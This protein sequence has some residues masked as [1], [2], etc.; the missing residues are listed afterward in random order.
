MQDYLVEK[1][2]W[3]I[4]SEN[5][6]PSETEAL[7]KFQLKL[8]MAQSILRRH[9]NQEFRHMVCTTDNTQAVSDI[10]AAMKTKH[11]PTDYLAIHVA[12][13]KMMN[14]KFKRADV[15]QHIN[16]FELIA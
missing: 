10:C 13:S 12:K 1:Q 15:V 5:P 7:K 4:I 14:L 8:P 16:N 9:M 6:A 2:I 11:N 3:Q